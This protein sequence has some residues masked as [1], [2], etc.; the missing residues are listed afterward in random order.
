[1]KIDRDESFS[2]PINCRSF[3]RREGENGEERNETLH[4][5]RNAS[6]CSSLFVGEK[7]CAENSI[8]LLSFRPS[9]ERLCNSVHSFSF[10]RAKQEDV[11]CYASRVRRFP[12]LLR[13]FVSIVGRSFQL[14]GR[15]FHSG[16][17]AITDRVV[18]LAF[19]T[20]ISRSNQRA[21][22]S[23]RVIE[24]SQFVD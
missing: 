21:E 19:Q 23:A 2:N 22:I 6:D 18:C 4:L 15:R 20:F 17:S 7:T 13:Q 1:M 10:G 12:L 8:S 5:N 24:Q 11:L 16:L 3:V 14:G 9:D